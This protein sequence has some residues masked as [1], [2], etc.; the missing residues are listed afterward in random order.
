MDKAEPATGGLIH[1]VGPAG[2]ACHHRD[3]H[4]QHADDNERQTLRRT[5]PWKLPDLD[6]R[7]PGCAGP[8]SCRAPSLVHTHSPHVQQISA[9]IA[10]HDLTALD[11]PV[12]A[13]DTSTTN[14]RT[15]PQGRLQVPRMPST[16]SYLRPAAIRHP[17]PPD[18]HGHPTSTARRR[19][20]PSRA[21]GAGPVHS[22][23]VR[24][25]IVD[26][27]QPIAGV[28]RRR[29]AGERALATVRAVP[30]P[31]ALERPASRPHR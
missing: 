8:H 27:H 7:H 14:C 15:R 25:G 22:R 21:G 3:Q 11:L 17:W 18:I 20:R 30:E 28:Y 23:A 29:H 26:P 10:I 13:T 5:V 9:D 4:T 31:V 19:R 12:P 6:N 2:T 1:T 16:H 24:L